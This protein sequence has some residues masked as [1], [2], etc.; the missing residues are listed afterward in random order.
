MENAKKNQKICKVRY[1]VFYT[2]VA[3]QFLSAAV[4]IQADPQFINFESSVFWC[5]WRPESSIQ[6]IFMFHR[7]FPSNWEYVLKRANS[8]ISSWILNH[9]IFFFHKFDLNKFEKVA[10]LHLFFGTIFF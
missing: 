3:L 8:A 5:E 10:I 2:A 7:T 1:G 6:T 9:S 4:F